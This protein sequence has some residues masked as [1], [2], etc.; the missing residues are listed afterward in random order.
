[1]IKRD[2]VYF[3]PLM[4]YSKENVSIYE[5]GMYEFFCEDDYQKAIPYKFECQMQV[6]EHFPTL[7]LENDDGCKYLRPMLFTVD[8]RRWA[9]DLLYYSPPYPVFNISDNN[10]C[11]NSNIALVRA[12]KMS[13]LLRYYDYPEILTFSHIAQI[14]ATF[15]RTGYYIMD[16]CELF[17]RKK[18]KMIGPSDSYS[19]SEMDLY[20][21]PHPEF[22][23]PEAVFPEC[24]FRAFWYVSGR[25]FSPTLEEKDS[26][27]TL[28]KEFF[29]KRI[30]M[31]FNKT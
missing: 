11:L 22:D 19:F 14:Y 28:E 27:K 8:E 13:R 3:G 30:D 6:L 31:D 21:Y 12:F 17:G 25:D 26:T 29:T 4:K 10:D 23:N 18:L 24:Y 15:F 2:N 1:M 5:D 20:S 16:N 7:N 9:E